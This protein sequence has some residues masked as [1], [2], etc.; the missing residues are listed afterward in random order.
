[1][2][3]G[4]FHFTPQTAYTNDNRFDVDPNIVA[5]EA[6]YEFVKPGGNQIAL[7]DYVPASTGGVFNGKIS[8]SSAFS[9]TNGNDI[10]YKS[11]VE[12]NIGDLVDVNFISLFDQNFALK[13][14]TDLASFNHD[15]LE[16]ITGSVPGQYNHLSNAEYIIAT[17]ACDGI[18]DGYITAVKWTEFDN[19]LDS[20][21]TG[22]GLDYNTGTISLVLNQIDHNQ[23]LNYEADRHL[24]RND[25]DSGVNVLWSS[26]KIASYVA[27]QIP[28]TITDYV[29]KSMGGEYA[30]LIKYAVGI[31]PVLTTD[32]PH[33]KY[34][35][36]TIA[37]SINTYDTSL[38]GKFDSFFA[39]KSL[40][41]LSNYQHALL[42]SKLGNGEYHLSQAEALI[43]QT[44]AS[45]TTNG[46]LTSTDW[47]AFS[48]KLSA[49]STAQDTERVNFLEYESGVLYYNTSLIDHNVLLNYNINQHRVLDDSTTSATTLWSSSKVLEMLNTA[50]IAVAQSYFA[51]D[52]LVSDPNTYFK[53]VTV[54]SDPDYDITE[55]SADA[56]VTG[57]DTFQGAWT[58]ETQTV[59]GIINATSI[60]C[61]LY[62]YKLSGTADVQ[63]YFKIFKRSA[64][65]VETEL[66]S[67]KTT[68]TPILTGTK[69][70]YEINGFLPTTVMNT[71]DRFVLKFY[72]DKIG[73]GTNPTVRYYYGG[74]VNPARFELPVLIASISHD[75]I[76]GVLD[77][78][79]G[80]LKGHVSNTTQDFEGS[81]GFDEIRLNGSD[82][83]ITTDNLYY[84][85][86]NTSEGQCY[87][88]YSQGTQDFYI[89]L[90]KADTEQ[91]DYRFSISDTS[92]KI[93]MSADEYNSG[94]RSEISLDYNSALISNAT[95]TFLNSQIIYPNGVLTSETPLDV[96]VTASDMFSLLVNQNITATIINV[97]DEDF[98]TK[99]LVAK[100]TVGGSLLTLDASFG[101]ALPLSE[102]I[103]STLNKRNIITIIKVYYSDNSSDIFYNN[104]V[105]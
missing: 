21:S 7:N 74:L 93:Y 76:S 26:D 25:S 84:F 73:A 33:K 36:D 85:G 32:I 20:L 66:L 103:S 94:K 46:Y 102:P 49:F 89:A 90:Q 83:K 54:T 8:Y 57:A 100:V 67:T 77:A 63:S 44:P 69:A 79:T 87:S 27:S 104:V 16:N 48:G 65:G 29:S 9:I 4:N 11:W 91:R 31:N 62:L 18:N 88:Y 14:L 59:S 37:S 81:K 52:S 12:D 23:L 24:L 75:A 17:T 6:S 13:N 105:L 98:S 1:M 61:I 22:N 28:A 40:N 2:K 86:Q 82:F 53:L 101:S 92:K 96:D 39:D 45:G 38:S 10:V 19:K 72:A 60:K 51:T 97:N 55:G 35:D 42:S 95:G 50:T 43:T 64:L 71:G 15:D 34:V 58:T 47:S 80:I 5:P 56:A 99:I 78:G 70:S 68:P 3:K 41:Q 30:S